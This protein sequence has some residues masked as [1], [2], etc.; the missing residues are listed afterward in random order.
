M[1]TLITKFGKAFLAGFAALLLV[2]GPLVQSAKADVYYPT[3][4]SSPVCSFYRDLQYGAYGDDV[5]CLHQY[6]AT[7]GYAV[8][9]TFYSA[10]TRAS[11]AAWQSVN[12]IYPAS[13]YFG[14]V[15]RARYNALNYNGGGTVI[16]PTNPPVITTG[17]TQQERALALLMRA[18]DLIENVRDDRDDALDDD[19]EI[20][21]ADEYLEEADNALVDA[22]YAYLDRDYDDAQD[23]AEYAIDAAEDAE[24]EIDSDNGNGGDRDDARD[25]IDDAED[26]VDDARDEVED[27][28]DAGYDIN[29]ARDFLDDAEDAYDDRDYDEAE[30]Y[31]RDAEDFAEDALDEIDY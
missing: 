27:A 15:S 1:K 8:S 13:G 4:N 3:T 28:D 20:G 7:M 17:N 6:L 12:G 11:V 18:H 21:D 23:F 29:D 22:F 5:S 30:D 14:T 19:D 25:A 24:D 26:R 16:Y 10:Q 31:A 9:G 2:G